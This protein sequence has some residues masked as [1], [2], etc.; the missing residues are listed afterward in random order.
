MLFARQLTQNS[1]SESNPTT[2]APSPVT[3]TSSLLGQSY[4]SYGVNGSSGGEDVQTS[5]L[6]SLWRT[7]YAAKGPLASKNAKMI[8]KCSLAYF[9]GSLATYGTPSAMKK[10]PGSEN[11]LLSSYITTDSWLPSRDI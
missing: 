7:I 2:R 8:V 3:E 5:G 6:T 4:A 10:A 1:H 9:L 11:P